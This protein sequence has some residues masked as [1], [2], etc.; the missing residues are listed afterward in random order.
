M[1]KSMGRSQP[2]NAETRGQ[3][4]VVRMNLKTFGK[5]STKDGGLKWIEVEVGEA[6]SKLTGKQ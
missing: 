3:K 4:R 5:E 6:K 1:R 2:P